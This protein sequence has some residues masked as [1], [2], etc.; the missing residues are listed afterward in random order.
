MKK[1]KAFITDTITS[2][3]T[4]PGP[5]ISESEKLQYEEAERIVIWQEPHRL[6]YF[7]Q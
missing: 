1:L 5:V 6:F 2:V 7:F 3:V 4:E